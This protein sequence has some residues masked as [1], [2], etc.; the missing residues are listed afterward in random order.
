MAKKPNYKGF[1]MH[2]RELEARG[3]G[4]T[5]DEMRKLSVSYGIPVKKKRR[6]LIWMPGQGT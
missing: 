6:K 5:T 4:L 1:V 3:V 2:L